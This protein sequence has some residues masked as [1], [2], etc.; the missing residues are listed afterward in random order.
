MFRKLGILGAALALFSIAGGHWAV[1]QSVAWVGM[2]VD[3]S[4]SS[5][6]VVTGFEHTFNGQYAC[7]LCRAIQSGKSKERKGNEASFGAKDDAKVKALPTEALVPTME[8]VA[9]AVEFCGVVQG[10]V[11][12]RAEPPP[13]PP[14]RRAGCAA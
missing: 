7:D 13:T 5:G 9:V 6:S 3:Y 2:L 1:L 8:R 10:R 14:P 12:V 11:V 4:Q